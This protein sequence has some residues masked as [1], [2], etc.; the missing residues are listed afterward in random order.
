MK[1]IAHTI[2]QRQ[3]ILTGDLDPTHTHTHTETDEPLLD[4]DHSKTAD[5]VNLLVS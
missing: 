5:S 3:Y 2:T 1:Q 4:L